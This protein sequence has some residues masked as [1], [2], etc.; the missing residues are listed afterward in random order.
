MDSLSIL[1]L[2]IF[3]TADKLYVGESLEIFSDL[4]TRPDLVV[5]E[6]LRIKVVPTTDGKEILKIDLKL[7][8][9]EIEHIHCFQDEVVEALSF[10]ILGSEKSL[11]SKI[12]SMINRTESDVL[13]VIA[14]SMNVARSTGATIQSRVIDVFIAG[15]CC[16]LAGVWCLTTPDFTP[17][18]LNL[19]YE[20]V[21]PD[22][23]G[24]SV[25]RYLSFPCKAITQCRFLSPTLSINVLSQILAF[26]N[27]WGHFFCPGRKI[28]SVPSIVNTI[29]GYC[30]LVC[31]TV[32]SRFSQYEKYCDAMVRKLIACERKKTDGKLCELRGE[33]QQ[34][35]SRLR[36]RVEQLEDI[37][38]SLSCEVRDLV[39]QVRSLKCEVPK[40]SSCHH[41]EPGSIFVSE[42]S[43]VPV[44]ESSQLDPGS[45]FHRNSSDGGHCHGDPSMVSCHGHDS[46]IGHEASIEHGSVRT[47]T[48]E[49]LT[50]PIID[51][52]ESWRQ[53]YSHRD[54]DLSDPG[55]F[56][57]HDYPDET[58]AG[59]S[60]EA[61]G[62]NHHVVGTTDSHSYQPESKFVPSSI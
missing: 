44:H 54:E 15:V 24:E 12:I 11:L 43:M 23:L 36:V 48:G 4:G 7:V 13:M 39:S 14:R 33:F 55:A 32:D 40:V 21:C 25:F 30:D 26:I 9:K 58:S 27:V 28:T 10:Q 45:V 2:E 19:P 53:D 62:T 56:V 16:Y 41:N 51:Q 46:S 31:S 61:S 3:L 20:K 1:P 17:F 52:T 5:K 50:S 35:N 47:M 22:V 42:S 6:Y 18:P 8:Y 29:G 57:Q 59:T 60:H 38:R 49:T 37:V 34:E